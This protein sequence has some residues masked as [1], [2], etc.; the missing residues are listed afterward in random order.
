MAPADARRRVP[1]ACLGI[2]ALVWIACAIDPV[3]RADWA[4]ENLPTAVILPL[5]LVAHR[6]V[7]F[8]DR[9]WIQGTAFLVLHTVGSH[10]T[11]SEVPLGFWVRDALDLGRNH[12][13]RFVHF[14]FGLLL[15]RPIRE[16]G[17][18]GHELDRPTTLF[19]CIAAVAW[20][21][22]GYEL[23]EWLVARLA[24]PAAGT[25]YLGTQGDEWD[26]QKDMGLALLGATLAAVW[27]WS[28]PVPGPRGGWAR[29]AAASTTPS[30]VA[31]R[32]ATATPLDS[33]PSM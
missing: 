24:D 7:G 9:A 21:S 8:S 20:W 3:Y 23:V 11:Y 4:L 31:I 5:V 14:A 32:R 1:A 22:V 30:R 28:A 12:Y 25:A 10:Y 2:F 16:L 18:R 27:E 29:Y 19:F 13:D 6:R 26:A 33:A 17:F 15:L